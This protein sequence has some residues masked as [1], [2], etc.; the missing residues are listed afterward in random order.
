MLIAGWKLDV[1]DH[2]ATGQRG[3]GSPRHQPRLLKLRLLH[4]RG[5]KE[6]QPSLLLNPVLFWH[7]LQQPKCILIS[8]DVDRE[9]SQLFAE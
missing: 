4:E 6:K 3:P 7:L 2:R 1:E 5:G 9:V 8:T